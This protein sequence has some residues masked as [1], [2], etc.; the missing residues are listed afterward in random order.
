M[1]RERVKMLAF[2]TNP[3]LLSPYIENGVGVLICMAMSAG[4]KLEYIIKEVL[5]S[6]D[7]VEGASLAIV[8]YHPL[9]FKDGKRF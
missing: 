4:S 6:T 9:E 7:G 2:R 8:Y 1:L 3:V 5:I